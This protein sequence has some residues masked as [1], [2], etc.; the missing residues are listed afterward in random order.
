MERFWAIIF[1]KRAK[2]G[3]LVRRTAISQ[4]KG[5]NWDVTD[6]KTGVVTRCS[7]NS[8][9]MYFILHAKI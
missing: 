3:K 6:F 7:E 9:L 4:R 2:G 1:V 5:E 8:E